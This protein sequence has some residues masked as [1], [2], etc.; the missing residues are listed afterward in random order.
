M[1]FLLPFLFMLF[2]CAPQDVDLS[3]AARDEI[4]KADLAMSSLAGEIGFNKALLTYAAEDLVKPDEGK[5]PVIGRSQLEGIFAG[6]PGT[7]TISWKPFRV[8][9]AM[10]GELG[11]SLGDWVFAT[12]DTTYYGNY[13]TIW[14]KQEDGKWKWVADGGN[15]TP[16]PMTN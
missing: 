3:L 7:K 8:E 2:A 5:L 15:N 12:I 14:K 13:Y 9:A 11:Y 16:A 4:M 6:E 1:K 10:S